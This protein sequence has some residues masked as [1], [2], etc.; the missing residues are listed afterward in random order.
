MTTRLAQLPSI[1]SLVAD[2]LLADLP[3]AAVVAAGRAVVAEARAALRAGAV[4]AIDVHVVRAR[5]LALLAP[6]LRRVINA[7]GVLLHTNLGRAPL[8][9]SALAAVVEAAA[10]YS[11][12]EFDLT[13]GARGSRHAHLTWLFQ[14]LTGAAA[15]VVVNNNA[16]A[17][18]LGLAAMAAGREVIVARSELIEIG[19]AFRLPEIL[20]MAGARMVA[21]GT[22]N[23]VRV[24]D[25]RRAIGP[26][27]ALLLKVHQSNFAQLGFVHE[28]TVEELGA[29][30]KGAGVPVMVDLGAGCL[31]DAAELQTV[32]L[33]AEATIQAAV[34]HAELVAFSGDK[35][36]GGPQAGILVGTE[37]SIARCQQHPWMR[38]LRPDKLAIAA[39]AA[40]AHAHVFANRAGIPLWE[41]L[42]TPVAELRQ[43]AASVVDALQHRLP[44]GSAQCSIVASELTPGG[45]TM[46]QAAKA[47]AAVCVRCAAGAQALVEALRKGAHPVIARIEHDSVWLDMGSLLPADLAPLADAVHA[48][49]VAVFAGGHRDS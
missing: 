4:T 6:P 3:H 7:T 17:T 43:R 16:A 19:G 2:P 28:V 5:A 29:L 21:V 14:A 47:S 10:G 33:P 36:L 27:T 9:A 40:T 34:T 25:Y 48:A 38:A 20:S 41:Q 37:A 1:A 12:L 22:T 45:G 49:V 31:A 15:A 30:G 18:L 44:A 23:K 35:L 13:T 26:A 39:L 11:N 24:A 46:P 42:R 8:S 32:G